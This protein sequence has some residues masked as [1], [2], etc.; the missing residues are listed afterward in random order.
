MDLAQILVWKLPKELTSNSTT[1]EQF[2][3]IW[4]Y[5]YDRITTKLKF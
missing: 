5:Y 2:K 4:L 1:S 3:K